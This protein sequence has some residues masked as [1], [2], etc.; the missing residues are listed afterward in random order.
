MSTQ[1]EVRLP[2]VEVAV[3][4]LATPADVRLDSS[5]DS[6]AEGLVL[7]VP[8][9]RLL[10]L[11]ASTVETLV[12]LGSDVVALLVVVALVHPSASLAVPWALIVLMSFAVAGLYGRRL[13]L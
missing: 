6:A 1:V 11:R 12:R 9:A 5:A 4:D 2:L 10:G 8:R 7:G 3:P 13:R